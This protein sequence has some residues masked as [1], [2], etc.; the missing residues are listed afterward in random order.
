[1]ITITRRFAS[2][3]RAVARRALGTSRASEPALCFT[4]SPEGMR[5]SLLAK[6]CDAAVEYRSPGEFPDEQL[7]LPLDLLTDCE[8]KR[9]DPVT[10][11]QT[12]KGRVLAGWTDGIPQRIQYHCPD[13]WKAEEFPVRPDNFVQNPPEVLAALDTASATTDPDAVR[14]ALGC[15]RLS[16]KAGQLAATD[17]RQ[18]YL[19]RGFVFLWDED[20]L[21]PRSTVF[22]CRE[23]PQDQP[24]GIGRAGDWVAFVVGPWT[25]YLRINKDGRF[26][27]LDR[28]IP[29]A[30][31][32]LAR[33][34]FS[35]DDAEFLLKSLPKLPCDEDTTTWQATVELNGALVVRAKMSTQAQPTELF[36]SQANIQGRPARVNTNRKYLAR[37]LK[38]GF[39]ELSIFDAPSPV[40][41]QDDRRLYLWAPLEPDS[42]I[43]PADSA[44]RIVW[45]EGAACSVATQPESTRN[46]STMS[47]PIENQNPQPQPTEAKTNGQARKPSRKKAAK[48][49]TVTLVEQAEELRGALRDAMGKTTA[50]IQAIKENQRRG[51]ALRNTLASLKQL[52]T[53]DA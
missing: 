41:C 31:A 23:V 24:I 2:S 44:V 9:N 50:L 7:W 33:C 10:L 13:P 48:N 17:G 14:Y 45:P 19:H 32:A 51:R 52:Q 26:P 29:R 11:E 12:A 53:V 39:R 22:G 49:A 34:Q 1:L 18:M 25:I 30:D 43:G 4:T 46:T 8:G 21:V 20:L 42:A 37:A 6:A 35:A 38:L 15:I 3:L 28:H 5:V 47:D 36:L 16:G 27:D 40:L